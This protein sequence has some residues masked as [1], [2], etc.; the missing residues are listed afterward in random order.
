[1][2]GSVTTDVALLFPGQGSQFVG[3]GKNVFEFPEA[4]KIFTLADQVFREPKLTKLCFEGPEDALRLTL[5]TQPAIFTV[6]V[7]CFEVFKRQHWRV[8]FG[9]GHSIGEYGALVASG[10]LSFTEA[11]HLVKRRGELMH[12]AGLARSG[13]MAAILGLAPNEVERACRE[14]SGEK[15]VEVANLN[16]PTQV[17]IS[18]DPEAVEKAGQRAKE[19]GA[20]RVIPLPV[21]GAF[22]SALM[23][24]AATQLAKEL[25]AVTFRDGKFPIVAN[26]TGKP[27]SDAES[28]RTSLKEQIRKKVRWE[29]SIRFIL[30]SGVKTFVEMEPGTVLSGLVR[31]IDRSANILKFEEVCGV[32]HKIS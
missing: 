13:T 8:K 25:D 5:N 28:I 32:Q 14:V 30:D 9:A 27:V 1:M 20:K 6:S 24:E 23:E 7:A 17:V 15:I 10:V 22:H 11:L 12:Q 29:E 31:S 3:M 21:S 4:Q 18:G 26:V 16:S 2:A 19:R